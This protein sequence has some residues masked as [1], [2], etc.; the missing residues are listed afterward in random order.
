MN[1][2]GRTSLYYAI[3]NGDESVVRALVESGADI[4]TKDNE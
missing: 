4:H 2:R 1:L 3:Q